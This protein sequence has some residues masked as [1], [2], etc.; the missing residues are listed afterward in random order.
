MAVKIYAH[1]STEPADPSGI[2]NLTFSKE[3]LIGM[4]PLLQLEIAKLGPGERF[5]TIEVI[6]SE[7]RANAQKHSRKSRVKR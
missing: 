4:A 5:V 2:I 7:P 3:Q 6:A 1:G